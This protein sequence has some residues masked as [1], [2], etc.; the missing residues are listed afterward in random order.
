MD[1]SADALCERIGIMI[2]GSMRCLGSSQ[3]LKNTYGNSY[4]ISLK[5]P[6]SRA[7][8]VEGFLRGI[9]PSGEL[10]RSINGAM[11]YEAPMGALSLGPLFSQLSA[12]RDELGEKDAFR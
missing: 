6:E 7:E 11:D 3:H 10:G 1:S 2:K 8:E 5:C 4:L 12:K 9:C